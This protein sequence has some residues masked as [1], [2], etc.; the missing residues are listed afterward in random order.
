MFVRLFLVI[1][2]IGFTFSSSVYACQLKIRTYPFAPLAVQNK[3]RS[4]SGVDIGYAKAFA[5]ALGCKP[6]FV[7]APWARSLA[8]LK[9]GDIDM[10][11]NVTKSA[12]RENDY[13]F[14]GPQR[15]ETIRLVS[16][17]GAFE[18]VDSWQDFATLDVVLM[19]Q[20]G[21]LFDP[22]FEKSLKQNFRLKANLVELSS[23]EIRMSLLKKNRID[24]T[25]VDEFIL[26]YR[27]KTDK[28]LPPLTVHPLVM[29]RIPVYFAFSKKNF[30][31]EQID[32]FRHTFE[33][34]S[35][36]EKYQM[37]GEIRDK[38]H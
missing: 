36:T 35:N 6:K 2:I 12:K 27:L 37:L 3:D 15:H 24:G 28:T 16:V 17:E 13:Y 18:K 33:W 26:R 19:R 21:S 31:P 20:K 25:F 22:G 23:N 32:E 9:N 34:F 10:M 11:V 4:W 30:T 29:S 5:K 7:V 1:L 8:L 14:I 38:T